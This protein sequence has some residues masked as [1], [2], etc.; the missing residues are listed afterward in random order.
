[1]RHGPGKQPLKQHGMVIDQL[2]ALVHC[3]ISHGMR[4]VEDISAKISDATSALKYQARFGA[5]GAFG[6]VPALTNDPSVWA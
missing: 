2:T 3:G 1:M 6:E 5:F 4:P